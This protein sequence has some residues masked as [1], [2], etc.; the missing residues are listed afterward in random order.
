MFSRGSP[1]AGILTNP[2][3]DIAADILLLIISDQ[4]FLHLLPRTLP[5]CAGFAND[6]TDRD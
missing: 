3:T 2:G 5:F 6:R 4:T 1:W